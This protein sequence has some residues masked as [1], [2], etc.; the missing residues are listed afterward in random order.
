MS[1]N[2]YWLVKSE[3]I[4]TPA[5]VIGLFRVICGRVYCGGE[6]GRKVRKK[7]C[8]VNKNN[9]DTIKY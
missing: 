6:L 3:K 4:R 8:T 2:I 1:T 9:T 5:F 7:L